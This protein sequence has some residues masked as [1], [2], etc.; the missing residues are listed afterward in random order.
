[1]VIR[2]FTGFS[3]TMHELTNYNEETE[4]IKKVSNRN[5]RNEKLIVA[6]KTLIKSIDSR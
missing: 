3:R 5:H 4:N 1:M 2:I 6:V